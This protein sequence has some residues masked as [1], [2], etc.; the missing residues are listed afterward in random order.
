MGREQ[1]DGTGSEYGH[2]FARAD[3]RQFGGVKSGGE[4]I[5]EKK[6]VVFPRVTGFAG[7][8]QGIEIG[9]GN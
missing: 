4:N 1:A 5:R 8:L 9:I 6:E 3:A 7:K 2:G